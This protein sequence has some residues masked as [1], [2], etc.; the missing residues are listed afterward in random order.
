MND[1]M[2][3]LFAGPVLDVHKGPVDTLP[4]SMERQW[5]GRYVSKG[6]LLLGSH[7][8]HVEVVVDSRITFLDGEFSCSSASVAYQCCLSFERKWL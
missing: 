8:P 6:H 7:L 1:P 3:M 4:L 5:T 2:R